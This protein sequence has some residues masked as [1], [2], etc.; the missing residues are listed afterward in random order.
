VGIVL[1][2]GAGGGTP[3]LVGLRARDARSASRRSGAPKSPTAS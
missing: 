2:F 3:Q 1:A